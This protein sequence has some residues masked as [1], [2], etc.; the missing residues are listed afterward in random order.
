MRIC[1]KLK[2]GQVTQ[3]TES[4]VET[5]G[6]P[7]MMPQSTVPVD[8]NMQSKSGSC[9][10]PPFVIRAVFMTLGVGGRLQV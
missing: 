7:L 6:E 9:T 8:M 4:S 2:V 1:G 10:P 3:S 5:P